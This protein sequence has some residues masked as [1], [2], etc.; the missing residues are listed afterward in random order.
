MAPSLY[1][2]GGVIG[3]NPSKIGGTW[4]WC[5]VED[6]R[7]ITSQSG[8]ITPEVAEVP[9]ITNNLTE[10]MAALTALD[11][12][13]WR[14]PKWNGVLHSDSNVTKQRLRGTAPLRGIPNWM[15]GKI[16]ELR[17]NKNWSMILLGGHPSK[18][19]LADGS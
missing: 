17:R 15:V 2:D 3:P 14:F 9:V 5:M 7:L 13:F 6:N 4:A 11:Y 10:M 16:L 19:E 1:C 12:I 18:K 8:I